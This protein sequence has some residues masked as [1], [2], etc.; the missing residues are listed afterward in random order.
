VSRVW[1]FL[2]SPR[3]TLAPGPFV[4]AAVVALLLKVLVDAAGC[5]VVGLDYQLWLY[6][7]PVGWA[8]RQLHQAAGLW[9]LLWSLPFGWFGAVLVLRRLRSAG[10]PLWLV[11][12]FFVPW[13]NQVLFLL[14]AVAPALAEVPTAASGAPDR[15]PQ[16]IALAVLV[17]ALVAL[18]SI[19]IC[20]RGLL[21]Y[22]G[23]VFVATPF[24]QGLLISCWAARRGF[25]A[26]R[27]AL[28]SAVVVAAG[29]LLVAW[30]GGVC[31]AMAA[32]IWLLLEVLGVTI[33]AAIFAEPPVP[34]R[35]RRVPP[36]LLLFGLAAAAGLE[37][38]ARPVGSRYLATTEVVV[39][40]PREVV[41][42]HLV[43]F[44]ELAPPEEWVFRA[45]IAHPVRASIEGHGPGAVRRCSFSTGDFVEPITVW[46]EP[47]LL[48][49][50]VTECPPPMREWNPFHDEVEAAHLHGYFVA[51][52]G[53][54]ELRERPDG[55]TE[56]AG[57]TWYRHGLWPEWYWAWWSEALVHTIHRRVLEHIRSEAE[58]AAR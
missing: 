48:R 2:S 14:L 39:Q 28:L 58:R 55:A 15:Q 44:S 40:A 6:L 54:F 50:T 52:Q 21:L 25:D 56:L 13:C 19:G 45:G 36:L 1:Q 30:E 37:A 43:A 10:W 16:P 51:E 41:W 31:I 26:M 34:R 53:Q 24:V 49:F 17:P 47:R 46:D 4:M 22:G 20:A 9:F 42:R 3:G 33:G 18:A 11:V 7:D 32:P 12:G 8:L 38:A 27:V 57:T 29:L 5:R 35:V 23:V